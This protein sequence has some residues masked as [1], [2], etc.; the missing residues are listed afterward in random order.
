MSLPHI[1]LVKQLQSPDSVC[2]WTHI[3]Y[4]PLTQNTLTCPKTL[5]KSHPSKSRPSINGAPW[6]GWLFINIPL[7]TAHH[8]LHTVNYRD[9]SS[10][11]LQTHTL[12]LYYYDKHRITTIDTL[13]L[14]GEKQKV[15]S[16]HWSKTIPHSS[17]I[18]GQSFFLGPSALQCL[19][20]APFGFLFLSLRI[21]L[22][23]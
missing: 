5:Q 11:S 12:H 18:D 17:C 22:F 19:L 21:P 13:I 20:I 6:Y 15:C 7:R 16:K 23:L 14:K 3:I 8:H 2:L 1:L 10:S 9:K 4:I